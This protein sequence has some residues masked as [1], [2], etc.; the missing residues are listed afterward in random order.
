MSGAVAWIIRHGDGSEEQVGALPGTAGIG[1][2]VAWAELPREIDFVRERFDWDARAIEPRLD[3]WRAELLAQVD[4]QRELAR[5]GAIT[6]LV[7]QSFVYAEKAREVADYRALGSDAV[8]ELDPST[9]AARFAFA[10]A[11][12]EATGD[13]LAAV[14]ARFEAGANASRALLARIDARA[15]SAKRA[16]RAATTPSAMQ[17]AAKITWES[18][19]G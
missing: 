9:T 15:T 10:A 18:E 4:A 19:H 7:G 17:A 13:S 1:E 12:V 3:V 11:E 16:I 6:A 5:R 14:F 2:G 8:A